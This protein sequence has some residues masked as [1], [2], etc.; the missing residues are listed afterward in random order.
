VVLPGDQGREVELPFPFPFPFFFFFFFFSPW[1]CPLLG[2]GAGWG[3][4]G[5]ARGE[6]D[7]EGFQLAVQLIDALLDGLQRPRRKEL[8][9]D[10]DNRPRRD[11]QSFFKKNFFSFF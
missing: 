8:L 4:G 9:P 11:F 7:V 3:R 6:G 5:G 1:A 10:L 2:L